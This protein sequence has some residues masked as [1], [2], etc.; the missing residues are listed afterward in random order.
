M[1]I[2]LMRIFLVASFFVAISQVPVSAREIEFD[3]Y[4][5][6]CELIKKSSVSLEMAY[7]IALKKLAENRHLTNGRVRIFDVR[8][9]GHEYFFPLRPKHKYKKRK[10]IGIYVSSIN[11]DARF[12]WNEDNEIVSPVT[13]FDTKSTGKFLK[14]CE[15]ARKRVFSPAL[16]ENN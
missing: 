1:I 13:L 10:E 2:I 8:T 3:S 7:S 15:E 6:S 4:S 5:K 9:I 14:Q 12:I 11:G 16:Q